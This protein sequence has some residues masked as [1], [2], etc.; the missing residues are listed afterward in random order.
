MKIEID[1]LKYFKVELIYRE[2]NELIKTIL[3]GEELY[4]SIEE[5]IIMEIKEKV[6]S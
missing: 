4:H 6:T 1:E 5:E 2:Q 3:M